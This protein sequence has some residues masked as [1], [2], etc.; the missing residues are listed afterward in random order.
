MN[1][2]RIEETERTYPRLTDFFDK[3]VVVVPPLR[4]SINFVLK[5]K[6]IALTFNFGQIVSR[7]IKDIIARDEPIRYRTYKSE[8]TSLIRACP[9]AAQCCGSVFIS[10]GSGSVILEYGSESRSG[11]CLAIILDFGH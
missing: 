1:S 4:R 7:F 5:Y 11:F 2:Y 10:F 8:F 3:Y 9:L 6:T